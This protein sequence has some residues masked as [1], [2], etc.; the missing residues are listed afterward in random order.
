MCPHLVASNIKSKYC[1]YPYRRPSR[2]HLRLRRTPTV[3]H[4]YQCELTA[5]LDL[6]TANV[7]A[8][9][10]NTLTPYADRGAIYLNK[11]RAVPRPSQ[12]D[13]VTY[14]L[15]LRILTPHPANP[16]R[17]SASGQ[18]PRLQKRTMKHGVVVQGKTETS[19]CLPIYIHLL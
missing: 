19:T 2:L 15:E 9:Y 12:R 5:L 3:W 6:G 14:Y 7:N 8:A 13:R 4:P 11:E 1:V 16:T 17:A 18:E 10:G